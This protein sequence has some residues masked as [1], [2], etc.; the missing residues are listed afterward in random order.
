MVLQGPP[1]DKENVPQKAAPSK[2]KTLAPYHCYWLSLAEAVEGQ[3]TS[4]LI[5]PA[6]QSPAAQDALRVKALERFLEAAKCG[7]KTGRTDLVRKG[8][9]HAWKTLSSRLG[10][11]LRLNERYS[12]VCSSVS[13]ACL[14]A[15]AI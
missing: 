14:E 1:A 6:R 11:Q 13:I 15:H 12:F 8:L 3:A 10:M 5:N 4:L 9:L 7:A 2:P